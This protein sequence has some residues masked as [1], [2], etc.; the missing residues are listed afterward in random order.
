MSLNGSTPEHDAASRIYLLRDLARG[1][2]H[3][4]I[5]PGKV[6]AGRTCSLRA[7]GRGSGEMS[8][9]KGDLQSMGKRTWTSGVPPLSKNV[10]V[11]TLEWES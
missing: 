3:G 10:M 5:Y 8:R 11:E 1:S 4:C 6:L 7:I 9:R 2:G